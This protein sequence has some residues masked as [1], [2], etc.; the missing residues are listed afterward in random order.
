[1]P[2]PPGPG[3]TDREARGALTRLTGLEPGPPVEDVL[4]WRLSCPTRPPIYGGALRDGTVF[5]GN[6][7]FFRTLPAD[8]AVHIPASIQDLV[9]AGYR[10]VVPPTVF[11]FDSREVDRIRRGDWGAVAVGLLTM[12]LDIAAPSR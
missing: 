1:M 10:L 4:M 3:G 7:K 5:V 6:G 12:V 8:E 11:G 9:D 2:C